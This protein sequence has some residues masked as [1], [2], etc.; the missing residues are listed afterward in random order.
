[1]IKMMKIMIVAQGKD[2][3]NLEVCNCNTCICYSKAFA[4]SSSF[5]LQSPSKDKDNDDDGDDGDQ[6]LQEKKDTRIKKK[7]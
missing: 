7:H 1:M 3:R 5:F 6:K 4:S 2:W